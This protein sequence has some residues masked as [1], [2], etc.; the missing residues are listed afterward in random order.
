VSGGTTTISAGATLELN[1]P[2]SGTVSFAT[3]SGTLKIDNSSNFGGSI[4]GQLA[5]G[6]VIDL[7]DVNFSSNTTIH[8]SGNNSSGT[9]TVSW[10]W[11]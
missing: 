3:S 11:A 6:D 1:S 4:A 2:F 8:Y 5:V 9:L 10:R 7:A